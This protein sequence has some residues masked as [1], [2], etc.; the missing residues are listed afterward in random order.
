[1]EICKIYNGDC[2]EL[3]KEVQD[4]SVDLVVTDCPYKIVPGGCTIPRGGIFRS[5]E[6]KT[7][8]LFK[9][10]DVEFSD[11]LPM[12]YRTLKPG[13]HAYI[14]VNERNIAKMQTAAEKSGF[15]FVNILIWEKN[16]MTPNRY[17]MKQTEYILLLRKGPARTINHPGTSNI[18]KVKNRIGNKYHPTEKPVDLLKVLIENSS[19]AGDV[20]L[21]PFMG[22]GSTGVACLDTGRK[23]IGIEIDK[24]YFD[25]ADTRINEAFKQRGSQYE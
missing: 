12:V 8:K 3:L 11:W 1:M 7:G 5:K 17:Y 13:T 6:A 4:E 10:N 14:M 21:D 16:T 20:V 23:F 18:I 19:H 24:K 2:L 15:K 9:H 22:S 25:V